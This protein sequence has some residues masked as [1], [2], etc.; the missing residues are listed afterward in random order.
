[1]AAEIQFVETTGKT[2]YCQLR[3]SVGQIWRVDTTVFEAYL[4]ANIGHYNIPAT[5][6]GAASG[7]YVATMPGAA[8][9]VY[10]VTAKEQAGGSPAETD[11]TVAVA[12]IQW[13]GTA[14]VS[15]FVPTITKN[16]ALAKFP[17]EMVSSTDSLTP[18]TGLGTT[19]TCQRSLDGAGFGNCAN[20]NIE[21]GN[22]AYAI[23][24]AAADTNA[25][26]IMFRFSA[27]GAADTFIT[28]I[29]QP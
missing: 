27:A 3:N 9:G 6:Q 12:D 1:M 26:T 25:N 4:T 21:V 18:K 10:S 23:D 8:A 13:S 15:M 11:V 28:V 24:L 22:G 5:E 7:Y 16:T 19:I 20:A 29:T 14:A 17:F 2:A